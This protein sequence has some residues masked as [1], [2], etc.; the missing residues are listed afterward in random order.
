MFHSSEYEL[1]DFGAGRKLERFG[2]FIL[3]RPSPAADAFSKQ[4]PELWQTAMAR[5]ERTTAENGVW[6]PHET[7]PDT[8]LPGSWMIKHGTVNFLIKPTDFGHTGVFPE[9][10]SN[11]DWLAEQIGLVSKPLK[12][13]NLFAYT[14][15]STLACAAAGA[16][17]VH[18]DAA[19]N[20]VDWARE[21]AALSNLSDAPIRWITEDAFKFVQREVRRGN[22]YDA[23]ILDPPS[24]GHGP[25][26]EVWKIDEHLPELLNLCGQLTQHQPQFIL[27]T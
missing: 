4:S 27:G 21:N 23:I 26:G 6:H 19:R 25:K 17:V 3:D 16:S 14:G 2:K 18:V 13:L 24:Y 10:Q 12:I 1:L 15:G 7:L 8:A 5:F 22:Q 11:W 20:V 9:Q